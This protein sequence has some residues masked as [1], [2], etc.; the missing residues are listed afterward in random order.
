MLRIVHVQDVH[1]D[2]IEDLSLAIGLGVE[3]I[4][5]CELGVQ[6]IPET[7]P[8]GDEEHDVLVGYDGMWYPKVNPSSFEEVIGSIGH[9][10]SLLTGCEDVDLRKPINSHKHIVISM[11]KTR[12]VIHGDGLPRL[13][14]NRKRGVFAPNSSLGE[15]IKSAYMPSW[16]LLGMTAV[17]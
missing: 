1:N 9:C 6:Q 16:A 10:D 2:H 12:H 8:K 17:R 11:W 13:L 4:G 5:F 7:R 15:Q 14:K 3:R